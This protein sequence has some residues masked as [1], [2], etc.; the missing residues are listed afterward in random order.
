V[1]V[2]TY[3]G[4]IVLLLAFMLYLAPI[5]IIICQKRN[6]WAEAL[7]KGGINHISNARQDIRYSSNL[8]GHSPRNTARRKM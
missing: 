4:A 1:P 5:V 6:D 3:L 8:L 2:E 7:L